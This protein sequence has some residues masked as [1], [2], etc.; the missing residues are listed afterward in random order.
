MCTDGEER[1]RLVDLLGPPP[2]VGRSSLYTRGGELR[3][4]SV[5]LREL[6]S[7]KSTKSTGYEKTSKY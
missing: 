3:R 4:F 2:Q 1:H 7:P 6:R 5:F